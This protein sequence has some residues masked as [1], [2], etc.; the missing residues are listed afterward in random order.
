MDPPL[1]PTPG[2]G[3]SQAQRMS[4]SSSSPR[5][6]PQRSDYPLSADS[7]TGN[8]PM[9]GRDP[10]LAPATTSETRLES[11]APDGG[12]KPSKASKRKKNRHRK[13]RNR[14]QSFLTPGREASHERSGTTTGTGGA[15]DSMEG[16]LATSKDRPSFFKLGSNLSN[17]SIDS[18]VL[19]DHRYVSLWKYSITALTI[20]AQTG[21]NL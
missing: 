10:G 21:S 11:P 19:L 3:G 12:G 8:G 15:R 20:A 13:R 2:I 14:Q 1:T 16:E 5:E 17:T 4:P 7:S 18:D 9:G 6:R